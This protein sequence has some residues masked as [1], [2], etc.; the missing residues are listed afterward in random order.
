MCK[1]DSSTNLSFINLI[2]E[3]TNIKPNDT[4]LS[5]LKA[6][7]F[8]F[9]KNEKVDLRYDFLRDFFTVILMAQSIEQEEIID[10]NILL[11]LEKK[12]GYLNSFSKEVAKRTFSESEKICINMI[13]NI[14]YLS[15]YKEE[16]FDAFISSLFLTYLS[17]LNKNSQLNTQN[18][19]QEALVSIFGNTKNTIE[20]LCLCN[21]NKPHGKPRLEFDFSDLKF[22]DF[23]IKNY[24][25]FYNC[26][27]NEGTLFKS[28]E[29]EL[30]DNPNVRHNLKDSNFSDKVIFL[31][32]TKNILENIKLHNEDR[33]RVRENN[34]K[35]FIKCFY[36]GGRFQSKKV[37]EIKAKHGNILAKMVDL[38][39]ILLH[40]ES[41][42]NEEEYKINPIYVNDLAKY[43]DSSI[44]TKLIISFLEKMA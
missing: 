18:D 44:K 12:I 29:I 35:K 1:Y 39:V 23:Y 14:E 7:P 27:F 19:L 32:N 40:K 5:L 36:A 22:D 34:F 25:E 33:D 17:I 6:H 13:N 9:E 28:G 4:L 41:K 37:A 38:E 15:K 2:E 30:L 10:R 8:I 42:L 20:H 31:G 26:K 16:H 3:V 21:I 11:I 24:S 43:L